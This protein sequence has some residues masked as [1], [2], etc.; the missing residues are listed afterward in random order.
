[1]AAIFGTFAYIAWRT[2]QGTLSIGAMIMYYGAFQVGL[3][4]LQQVL[5]GLAGLYEDNLFLTYFHEFQ[6]LERTVHDPSDPRPVPRPMAAGIAF[7][8][9]SFSYPDT[10]RSAIDNVSFAVRP[11][12]VTA[13]VGANGS[14]KTTLVKLLC[15]LYDPQQ[16]RITIDGCDLRQFGLVDL[17][18]AM[19]VIFQDYAQYQLTARQNIWIGNVAL[20]P[21]DAAIE[22][23]ARDSEP[24]PRSPACVTALRR[25][26]ARSS[27]TARSSASAS[28]RRWLWRAPSYAA[29]RSSCSTSPRARSTRSPSG[30]SSNTSAR[31]PRARRCS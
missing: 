6:T 2:V 8:N 18:R 21:D 20:D 17:R 30:A 24:P 29:P 19:S 14:G 1:M 4:S 11:G 23:A 7:E 15:R 5:G 3:S 28:G 10:D 16:G 13:L 31:W 25:S 9:V 22:A 12:E 26:S 27:R